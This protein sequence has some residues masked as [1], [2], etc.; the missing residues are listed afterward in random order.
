VTPD[1]DPWHASQAERTN[2]SQQELRQQREH[3]KKKRFVL[4]AL[5]LGGLAAVPIVYKY[6]DSIIADYDPSP[7]PLPDVD[8]PF[9]TTPHD[10]VD[11]MLKLANVTETD[12]V[13]D[14]GCGDG[15]IVVAA[16][17]KYGCKAWGFDNNP[18]RVKEARA[19]ALEKGVENLVTIE[20]QDLFK[21]DLSPASVVTLYLLPRLN[22][23]LIP[24]L[25]K[26]KPGSRI[27]SH[28]WDMKGVK[29]DKMIEVDSPEDN[30]V[31]YL[32]LWTAPLRKVENADGP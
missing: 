11:E 19:S 12:V 8:A 29:P 28:D 15:R 2:D 26:L 10:I 23:K 32:Y 21:L 6:R 24:Q 25:E 4:L 1:Q 27:V 3:G 16:A 18:E 14:L 13:Y 31:H 20:Q 7:L 17:E 9:I 22:V 30:K 5:T